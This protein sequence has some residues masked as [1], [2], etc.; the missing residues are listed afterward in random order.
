MQQERRAKQ[1]FPVQVP[2]VVTG[3]P[4]GGEIQGVT[5]DVSSKGVFFYPKQWSSTLSAITFKMILPAEITGTEST[6]V[7]CKGTVVRLEEGPGGRTGVAATI[8]TYTFG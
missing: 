4:T 8:D 1:R 3:A 2:I 7:A 6:R 5:R